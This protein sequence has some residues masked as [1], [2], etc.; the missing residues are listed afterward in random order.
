[1]QP[2]MWEKIFVVV[3]MAIED[4]S[5]KSKSRL[6][7]E[8]LG[9]LCRLDIVPIYNARH[10]TRLGYKRHLSDEIIMNSDFIKSGSL[11]KSMVDRELAD[12]INTIVE[13]LL[14]KQTIGNYIDESEAMYYF[15]DL[16]RYNPH[17]YYGFIKK[18]NGK[19]VFSDNVIINCAYC[20]V[21]NSVTNYRDG[22]DDKL[23]HY[24]VTGVSLLS[25]WAYPGYYSTTAN[26]V[27][28][29]GNITYITYKNQ[30]E[31]GLKLE[32]NTLEFIKIIMSFESGFVKDK[33]KRKWKIFKQ[34]YLDQIDDRMIGS[35]SLAEDEK[36][37]MLTEVKSGF[38][39][40]FK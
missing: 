34:F 10:E 2:E 16:I 31:K 19:Y 27:H 33:G 38:L 23:Y 22:W 20:M 40:L 8:F 6:S 24:P 17:L 29:D 5:G 9:K 3:R 25:D 18:V 4:L 12:E 32:M 21:L 14:N 15:L 36:V 39:N 7:D 13:I 28:I 37:G 35:I 1:M 30:Y 11:D 26:L